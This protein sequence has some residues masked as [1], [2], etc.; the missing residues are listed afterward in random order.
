[1]AKYD[2]IP[3]RRLSNQIG[4]TVFLRCPSPNS[5]KVPLL[6]YKNPG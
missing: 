2:K 4:N 3:N 6:L 1:M 5:L